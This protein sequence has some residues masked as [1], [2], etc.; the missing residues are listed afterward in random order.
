MPRHPCRRQINRADVRELESRFCSFSHFSILRERCLWFKTRTFAID[1]FFRVK[2]V[3][4]ISV[5]LEKG[6]VNKPKQTHRN[7]DFTKRNALKAVQ[8]KP[9][10]C[11][12]SSFPTRNFCY[13]H[14]YLTFSIACNTTTT[15]MLYK[16]M[17]MTTKFFR[18][19]RIRSTRYS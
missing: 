18:R 19:P 12:P 2:V 4:F 7:K 10:P 11:S 3:D 17:R 9:V 8:P 1:T 5:G 14:V 13:H 16:R 6:A 15:T